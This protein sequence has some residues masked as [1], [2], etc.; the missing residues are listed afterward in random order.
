MK[1]SIIQNGFSL[2]EVELTSIIAVIA[3]LALIT[4]QLSEIRNTRNAL[5]SSHASILFADITERIRA[6]PD[7]GEDYKLSYDTNVDSLNCKEQSC[8]TAQLVSYDL[9]TWQTLLRD[10]LP[11][12]GGGITPDPLTSSI[13]V[14]I[15]WDENNDGSSTF[16]CP[17]ESD[18]DLDCL[19]LTIDL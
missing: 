17:P 15:W 16:N 3:V 19:K 18:D 4:L 7:K 6:N 12:G 14:A 11:S 9:Q 1:R 13:E 2:L 10:T 8:T 5:T